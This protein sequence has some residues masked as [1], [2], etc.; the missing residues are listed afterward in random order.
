[1]YRIA[2]IASLLACMSGSARPEGQGSKMMSVP[3][4]ELPLDVRSLD[5]WGTRTYYYQVLRGGEMSTLG[6]VTMK[7]T[8]SEDGVELHDTL[9]VDGKGKSVSLDLRQKCGADN[10][11]QPTSI[12]SR[13][14]GDNELMT[15]S[16]KVSKGKIVMKMEDGREKTMEF[17]SDTITG[18]AMFR[19][20]TLL[21]R[22]KGP[23]VRVGNVLS[24]CDPAL[25]GSAVIWYE[26][27][28]KITLNGREET[29]HKFVR[30][31]DTRWE[32]W[33]DDTGIL[34]RLRLEGGK[35]MTETRGDGR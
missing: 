35:M 24:A 25:R 23:A 13:G 3:L 4:A 32:A 31:I 6:T 11:L 1:M 22:K 28:D 27:T 34:R 12:E 19:V 17:P 5:R 14:Q 20:F 2:V 8:L 30:G 26:G 21:P 18:F 16:A 9:K 15:F 33:V 7:T 29:L 10:L